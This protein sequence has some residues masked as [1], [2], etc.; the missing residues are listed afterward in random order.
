MASSDE[1]RE[2]AER[3]WDTS[4]D[5]L[6][7]ESLQRALAR[8]T[9]AYDTSWR[10]VLRRLAKLIDPK[11]EYVPIG[12]GRFGCT[13]CGNTVRLDFDVP[14]TDETPMPFK[15]CMN[16]GARVVRGDGE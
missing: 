14:V 4:Y 7:S 5:S 9:E 10:G 1:R 16:C 12:D 13:K 8:I 6:G 15:H 11:C 2:V 3:L